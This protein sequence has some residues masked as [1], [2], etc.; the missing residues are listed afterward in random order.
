MMMKEIVGSVAHHRR[1]SKP[2]DCVP[3]CACIILSRLGLR[4]SQ[5]DVC[6][7]WLGSGRGYAL[8]DAAA[9][10]RKRYREVAPNSAESHRI[11]HLGLDP[12]AAESYRWIQ[13]KLQGSH[14]IV[15]AMFTA[16]IAMAVQAMSPQPDSDFGDIWHGELGTH[17]A[18]VVTGV[19]D[20][21]FYYLDPF[22][23]ASGQPFSM[24]RRDF[25]KAFTGYLIEVPVG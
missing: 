2:N 16:K 1:Q 17:H 9:V 8:D 22:Y 12:D 15:A 14:W 10:L 11:Q 4:M 25:A 3:T 24:S 19:I 13:G 18:V 6:E 5:D 7:G 21:R 20:R 23:S